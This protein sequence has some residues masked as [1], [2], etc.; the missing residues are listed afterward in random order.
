MKYFCSYSYICGNTPCFGNLVFDTTVDP[1]DDIDEFL[2][3]FDEAVGLP[4]V[5]LLFYKK[6]KS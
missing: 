2:D 5:V 6:V 1:Y 4:Q 3:K